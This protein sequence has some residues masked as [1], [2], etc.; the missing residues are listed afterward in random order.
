MFFMNLLVEAKRSE[1]VNIFTESPQNQAS[2]AYEILA[3][4]DPS[5]SE[6][7]KKITQ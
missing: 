3:E 1:F 6:R 2:R 4:I 7:Y 5:Q